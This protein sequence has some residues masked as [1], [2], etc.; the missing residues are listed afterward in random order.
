MTKRMSERMDERTTSVTRTPSLRLYILYVRH[1]TSAIPVLTGKVT[2]I[3]RASSGG[4]LYG[5]V[6]SG[7]LC[8]GLV[9]VLQ[10]ETAVRWALHH[11]PNICVY[12]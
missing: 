1:L 11:Q 7:C 9:I 5:T 12:R 4:R 2:F 3:V 10:R 8:V 6:E